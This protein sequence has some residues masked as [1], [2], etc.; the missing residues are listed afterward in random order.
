[1]MRLFFSIVLGFSIANAAASESTLAEVSRGPAVVESVQLPDPILPESEL[2][3]IESQIESQIAPAPV[4]VDAKSEKEIAVQLESPV[5]AAETSG[6]FGRA[7]AALAIFSLIGIGFV[8]YMRRNAKP[9]NK[10]QQ[11]QIKVLTQHWL[12][13]KK[14]LSI[15][16]VAGETILIGITDT[17]ISHIK[18]LSL[19][20]E[21]IPE[22][23]PASF[24]GALK[25]LDVQDNEEDFA[26]SGIKDFVSKKLKGMRTLE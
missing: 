23:V 16:R 25:N 6:N 24:N 10:N 26:I 21:E 12:G 9:G 13:P 15:I 20:D 3:K 22:D 5:K 4:A 18:T 1:M 19:V 11:T 14:Q 7:M 2:A 17:Q 8:I